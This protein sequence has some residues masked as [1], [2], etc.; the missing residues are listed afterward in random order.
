M[1]TRLFPLSLCLAVPFAL[2]LGCITDKDVIDSAA[3]GGTETE[4][5]EPAEPDSDEDGLTDAEEEV[6]G[7]DPNDKD[8]DDDGYWDS[9]EVDEG[10][11]PL[12]YESRIYQGLWPYNPGKDAL[13]Q[14]N[15]A[16]ATTDADS[17]FPRKQFLDHHGDMVDIYDF[18]E[19]VNGNDELAFMIVD[20]SAMWCGPCHNMAD[21]IAGVDNSQTAGLQQAYPTVRDKVHEGRIW[22]LTFIV[23]NAQN[24]N[25]TIE[26]AQSWYA[27]HQDPF[28][29]ILVDDNKDILNV[30]NGGQFPF[31]F[32]LDPYMKI[33][34]WGI[35]GPGDN[36]FVPLFYV[37]QYL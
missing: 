31:F 24:G 5:G 8:T 13:D 6:I 18:T 26:D 19:Y 16:T 28:I 20:L 35:P 12:D 1:K 23:E 10:T 37:D 7:T 17:L 21:W 32:L 22:W 34:F 36:P 11:D 9:W 14:G 4:T 27:Q 25:P 15:M 2:G 33:E 29:P 3:D 30:Y